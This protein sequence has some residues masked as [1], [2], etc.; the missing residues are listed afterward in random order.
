MARKTNPG[1]A[2][3]HHRKWK[4]DAAGEFHPVIDDTPPIL[5]AEPTEEVRPFQLGDLV[6]SVGRITEIHNPQGNVQSIRVQTPSGSA[7][8]Q[9]QHL[10]HADEIEAQYGNRV[11]ELEATIAEQTRL[12][13]TATIEKAALEEKIRLQEE[14]HNATRAR[15]IEVRLRN[16]EIDTGGNELLTEDE[17]KQ[18]AEKAAK[19]LSAPPENKALLKAPQNK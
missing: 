19:A 17:L 15:V 3:P 12:L 5:Q 13:T 8:Y 18:R 2:T 6:A 10:M 14:Q 4:Q 9:K 1:E 11:Q 16:G 7:W